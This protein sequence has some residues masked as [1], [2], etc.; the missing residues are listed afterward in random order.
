MQGYG[1][2]RQ[3]RA[4]ILLAAIGVIL[5]GAGVTACSLGA[6]NGPST[7][8]LPPTDQL[9]TQS[10]TTTVPTTS[11]S[12]TDTATELPDWS[13]GRVIS[14]APRADNSSYHD[15]ATGPTDPLEESSGFH[16]ST[17]DRNLSCSTGTNGRGTLACRIN[18]ADSRGSR[19]ASAPA[20]CKWAGNLITLSSNGPTHGA[21]ANEYPVLYR[22]A[23]VDF[24]TTIAID[25]FSCLVS[26]DG[27]YC[28]ESSS[29]TGFAVTATGYR[30]IYANERA[31]RALLGLEGMD[32]ST[33]SGSTS[34]TDESST[35]PATPS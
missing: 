6:D 27:T 17:P 7:I 34:Q 20:S 10:E 19:P 23:I 22:S 15:G 33:E 12:I 9:T 13:L 24:G 31:P 26:P 14:L 18:D 1:S 29:K 21:C 8:V 35:T 30:K 3:R 16:F 2:R 32:T 5:L 28:L 4:A 11:S 25:R